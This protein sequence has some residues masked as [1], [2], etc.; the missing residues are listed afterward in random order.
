MEELHARLGPSNHRWPHCPGSPREEAAYQDIAG[1]AAID[2]TGSHLLL[3]LCLQNNVRAEQYDMQIIG[4]NHHD[5]PGGWLVDF[6]RCERVQQCLDYITRRVNELSKQLPG[7][8][9][10][11]EAEARS[12]P[13]GMVGRDDWWGTCDVTILATNKHNKCLFL[14]VCDYKD[15][16]M[17]VS[18]KENT[19]LYSYLI[20]KARPYVASGENLTRPADF[21]NISGGYRMTIVQ[22]KTNPSVRYEDTTAKRVNEVLAELQNAAE[23]TDDPN[24]PLESGKHCRW[25]KHKDNCN[26]ESERSMETIATMTTDVATT[27][28]TPSFSLDSFT[29]VLADIQNAS[30]EVLVQL[31]D[32]KPGVDA[33]FKKIWDEIERRVVH[34]TDVPGFAMRPGNGKNV[35]SY[36]ENEIATKLKARRLKKDEIYPSKLISPAQVLKLEKLSDSQKEKIQKDLIIHMPGDLTLKRVAFDE[37]EA[38]NPAEL[39]FGDVARNVIENEP[40]T[41]TETEVSFL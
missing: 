37:P 12:D 9:V 30:P 8:K 31:T 20:G 5:R 38:V 23:L 10:K 39:M 26:A 19:Q 22:P 15:G 36:D 33:A 25:C 3:E 4:A 16:R 40:E 29:A 24:A 32:A 34:G 13:G 1:E 21:T 14:E 11:V 18:E 6:E 28:E 17:F 35:W 27:G 7:S 2:G 41:T